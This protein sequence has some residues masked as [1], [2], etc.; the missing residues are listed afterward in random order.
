MRFVALGTSPRGGL[1]LLDAAR[2]AAVLAGRDY[3]LPD[4]LKRMLGPCWGHRLLLKAESEIEG[5]TV[6][7]ILAAQILAFILCG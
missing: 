3:A 7:R 5:M 4:D 2:A 6:S 1:C